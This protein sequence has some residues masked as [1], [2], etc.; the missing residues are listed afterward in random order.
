MMTMVGHNDVVLVLGATGGIGGA[1]ADALLARGA[2]VRALSRTAHKAAA[3][4]RRS[5]GQIDW[6]QGDAMTAADVLRAAQGATVIV[7][8]VNPARYRQWDKLVMPM[9][10][11]TIA[12][13]AASGATI[14][15]PGTVYTFGRDVFPLI[16]DGAPQ[17]PHTRKGLIR[18]EMENRLKQASVM[19]VR[20]I[21]LRAGDFFGP[22]AGNSWFGQAVVKPGK[23][24]RSIT[25]PGDRGV[26]HQWAY[27]PDVAA[28]MLA[29]LD[30][31]DTLAPFEDAQFDG[32]WDADGLGMAKA[33]QRV[34]GRPDIPVRRFPWWSLPFA[35]PF[36]ETVREVLAMRYLWREATRM[37]NAKLVALIGPEPRTSIDAAIETTLRDM[38][39]L[40][41][42]H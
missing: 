34:L 16:K 13:A 26:G 5:N 2:R 41:P 14:L 29:L 42:S 25:L 20:S 33:V 11:N 4:D 28:A 24:V 17:N 36:S 22:S 3:N 1:V 18:R 39:C 37:D 9:L 7:H 10:E 32:F 38:K 8:A 21:V 40:P 6:L 12:A 23:P 27:T 31:R 15:L 19:G 35:A 30:R